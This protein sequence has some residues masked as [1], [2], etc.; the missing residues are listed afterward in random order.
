M[1]PRT[2][3]G[4]RHRTHISRFHNIKRLPSASPR[5]A[6][7]IV[8]TAS[9]GCAFSLLFGR[10]LQLTTNEE[11]LSLSKQHLY[12]SQTSTPH[13]SPPSRIHTPLPLPHQ[14]PSWGRRIPK[15]PPHVACVTC[16]L[17]EHEWNFPGTCS[18]ATSGIPT[19]IP[20]ARAHPPPPVP[21][22]PPARIPAPSRGSSP[23]G[24][25]PSALIPTAVPPPGAASD[26]R[27]SRA[28][29]SVGLLAPGPLRA[30]SLP[31][32]A[33]ARIGEL[34]HTAAASSLS[35]A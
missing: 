7:R 14:R 10:Q 1:R 5:D 24:S 30:L 8:L 31:A 17:C 16:I 18:Q 29:P 21:R 35:A 15:P 28:A 25:I 32:E 12:R 2:V 26:P 20:P 4:S 33:S 27:R 23:R 3:P 13:S 6:F 19:H 22:I 11:P 9:A 34:R